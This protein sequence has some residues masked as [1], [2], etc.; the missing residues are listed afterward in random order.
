MNTAMGI[1]RKIAGNPPLA[2][3]A[4]KEGL[5]RTLEP[6]WKDTGKWANQQIQRLRLTEDSKEGVRSFLEKRAA[7]YVGR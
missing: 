2:V 1:A 5:R 6:D 3:Q 4:I 7:V